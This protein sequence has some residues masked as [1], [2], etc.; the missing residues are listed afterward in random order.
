MSEKQ[1]KIEIS[2]NHCH[3]NDVIFLRVKSIDFNSKTREYPS[4]ENERDSSLLYELAK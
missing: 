4:E 2:Q 1:I 3:L